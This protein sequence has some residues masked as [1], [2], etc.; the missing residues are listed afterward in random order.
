MK[1]GVDAT[2]ES[3]IACDM[4]AIDTA[5]RASHVEEV[6]GLLGGAIEREGLK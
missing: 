6:G 4:G 5:L 3:P 2:K 1:D